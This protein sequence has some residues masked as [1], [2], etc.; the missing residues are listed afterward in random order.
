[1]TSLELASPNKRRRVCYSRNPRT[2]LKDKIQMEERAWIGLWTRRTSLTN[3]KMMRAGKRPS[4]LC[5]VATWKEPTS[6]QR[7]LKFTTTTHLGRDRS[8]R[9]HL[10]EI[11][12]KLPGKRMSRITRSLIW[13]F[14]WPRQGIRR[15]WGNWLTST[16]NSH[17]KTKDKARKINRDSMKA[18]GRRS[19]SRSTLKISIMS[20]IKTN[21][22]Q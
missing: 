16:L 18:C 14:W 22:S 3:S 13:A 15:Q 17:S 5:P 7:S 12:L 10:R 1:M 2:T 9:N 19:S 4:S 11:K 21:H 8:L 6:K 20:N